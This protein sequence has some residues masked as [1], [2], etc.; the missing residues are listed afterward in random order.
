MQK[1]IKK[2]MQAEKDSVTLYEN[3]SK[4]SDEIEVQ[5]FFASRAD[6]ERMHFNY[7]LKYYQE[8]SKDLLPS[9]IP[10]ELSQTKEKE[11]IFSESF[12]RRIG[13]DQYLFS[14]IST[15][16]LLEKDAFTH[17][18]DSAKMVKIPELKKFFELLAEWEKRHYGE[19]LLIQQAAERY[20]WE[21]NSFQPF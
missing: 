6:E 17:Y 13:E 4:R 9:D 20:Y 1:A 16:L 14:A 7:L 18:Q 2:A 15:A 5:E 21:I 11:S 8:I 3:A 10:A 19:L 12:I